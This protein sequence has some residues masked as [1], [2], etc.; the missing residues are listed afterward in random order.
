MREDFD[1]AIGKAIEKTASGRIDKV[2][3]IDL[4]HVLSRY[5]RVDQA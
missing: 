4:K 5:Q 1:D 3:T 2:A